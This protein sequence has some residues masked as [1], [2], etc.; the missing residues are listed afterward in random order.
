M[1]SYEW[2]TPID[3]RAAYVEKLPG[4]IT[5]MR[6]SD[7][8]KP[9]EVNKVF[10]ENLPLFRDAKGIIFDIRGN[11]GGT[12]E[13]WNPTVLD[14]IAPADKRPKCC[15]NYEMSCRQCCFSR[16]WQSNSTA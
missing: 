16:I 8:T 4:N 12:D 7:F 15:F 2:C 6:M 5:Y 11:R 10:N 13:S 14:Y 3:K 1:E 9:D